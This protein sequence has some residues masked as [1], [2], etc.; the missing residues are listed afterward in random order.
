M[1]T[2]ENKNWVKLQIVILQ[3][4]TWEFSRLC[5]LLPNKPP[6]CRSFRSQALLSAE[7]PYVHSKPYITWMCCNKYQQSIH[8][9]YC[10]IWI[11]MIQ[12]LQQWTKWSNRTLRKAWWNGETPITRCTCQCVGYTFAVPQKT[13]NFVEA[14]KLR[15]WGP[16]AGTSWILSAY[17]AS[18]IRVAWSGARRQPA[19]LQP[20]FFRRFPTPL[21]E[22]RKPKADSDSG[23]CRRLPSAAITF[24][25]QLN[26]GISVK[27]MVELTFSAL[28][29]LACLEQSLAS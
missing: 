8:C 6:V 13:V 21:S 14:Q 29:V 7:A 24:W 5:A 10:Q 11:I 16:K 4:R 12:W 15:T 22:Y 9:Q 23:R 2:L 27:S 1:A 19:Q 26:E 25:I 28:T 20:S 18:P 17:L 3:P